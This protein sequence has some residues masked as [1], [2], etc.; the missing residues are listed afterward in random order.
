M[1]KSS[2]GQV[3]DKNLTALGDFLKNHIE[4]FGA[5]DPVI[6]KPAPEAKHERII[7]VLNAASRAKV[8]NLT[9]G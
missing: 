4:T 9:F 8:E 6:I 1:N 2:Y 3:T 7:D 5:K